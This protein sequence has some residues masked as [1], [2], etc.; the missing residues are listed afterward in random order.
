MYASKIRF[1]QSGYHISFYITDKTRIMKFKVHGICLLTLL[2]A[3]MLLTFPANNSS[4]RHK[5]GRQKRAMVENSKCKKIEMK[6]ITLFNNG[7]HQL[8]RGTER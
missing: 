1:G 7:I 3:L 6:G 4:N 5:H 2:L 8:T